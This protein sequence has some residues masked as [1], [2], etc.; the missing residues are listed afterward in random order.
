MLCLVTVTDHEMSGATEML[1]CCIHFY[2]SLVLSCRVLF[3]VFLM[4]LSAFE[5]FERF[6]A[7]RALLE[8]CAPRY[9]W[10]NSAD[11]GIPITSRY[12]IPRYQ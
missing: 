2:C 1:V 6:D 7:W 9:D 4:D 10:E 5:R 11:L 8:F 3:P 12:T